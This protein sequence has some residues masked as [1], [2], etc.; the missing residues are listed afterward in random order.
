[1]SAAKKL[2]ATLKQN[3]KVPLQKPNS[4]YLQLVEL[5]PLQPIS[6]KAQHSIALKIIENL[7]SFFNLEL[8][9]DEGAEMYL[10]ALT[11]LVKDYERDQFKISDIN[12]SEML[13]YL[14][15]LQ[16][17]KQSDLSKELGE[18]PVVSKILS[19]ERELNLR[20]FKALAKRFKV[21]PEVFI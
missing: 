9:K 11:E 4:T 2:I 5:F 7:I 15:D 13:S 8:F 16:G 3:L 12:G 19:G 1:M 20:Q 14:M 10:L 21:S 17:L 18:Q 6:S